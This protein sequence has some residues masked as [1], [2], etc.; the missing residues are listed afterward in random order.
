MAGSGNDSEMAN[1]Q[2]LAKACQD[3]GADAL[4][5]NL[6]CPHM[7]RQD[8]GSN[9]GK[10]PEL[11]SIVTQAVKEVARVPVWAK[12]TPST[13]D[14]IV[15][16]RG[17][18]LGGADAICSSN[19]FPSLPLID[20]E[21]LEFEINV[22]GMV[23]I[24][25]LGGPAIL[26]LSLAKMVQMTQAFPDKAFS[27]IGGIAEFGHALNYFLLGCGTVQVCTAAM[28][29]H[30][31]GP[32]VLKGLH[33]GHDGGDGAQR[34][35][36]AGR[37]HRPA[38]RPGRRALE[39]PPAGSRRLS[40]RLRGRRVRGRRP[41]GRRRRKLSRACRAGAEHDFVELTEDLSGSPLWNPDL[42]PTPLARRTWSTYHIAAL[43]IGMSVAITTYTLASGLMQQGMN[44]WQAMLT[45][46]L[47]NTIVLV[48]MILNAHAGTKYGVSFPVLCRASFG[49]K[50]ANIPAMLRALVACGWFGIQT[51]IGGLALNTLLVAAWPAWAGVSGQCLDRLRDFLGGTGLAHRQRPRGHQ[52]A[53]RL[54]GAAADRRRRAAARVG[55]TP[56]RRARSHPER[57]GAPADG[58]HP[59]LAAVSRGADRQHRLL[60]DAQPQYP[61]LHAVSPAASDR[62]RMG[63][64][65]GLPATMTAFAF[66][67]VAVTSATIVLFGEAIWDP[68]QV[69]ARIGSAP[70]I[71]FG[72]LV[73]MLAQIT[74][75]MAANVVSPAM[76]FSSLAPRR[77]S[78]VAG[79][80][81]TAVI[82][83][84]MMPWKLYA[85]AAAYIFTWLV[86]YS[87]LMGAIGGILIADYWVLRRQELSSAD[88]FKLEGRY[89]YSNGLNPRALWALVLAIA[90]GGARLPARRRHARRPGGESDAPRLAVHVR[91]VRDVRSE[92]RSVP[93]VQPP[94]LRTTINAEHAEHA[95]TLRSVASA[96]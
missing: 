11:I 51:W 1:W 24:G 95:E 37:L 32:N 94:N 93:G 62:R 78:Y 64:A 85:D 48:P 96:S 18:F 55:D 41:P 72:A 12:L 50:G 39:D 86:G 5:L 80:L 8:M 71:I 23:S 27:G 65:L 30:A 19:T 29:D 61:R 34:L 43:W 69:I 60:G 54:V 40:R 88:L 90:A 14:I 58:A 9:I 79:G 16:A 84:L 67:G 25:G 81:I 31:I 92:L 53:R 35:E 17:A 89:T 70:V 33:V 10:D 36:V 42:A 66:I 68:V 13:T 63:Q 38:A 6:S 87:S 56:G 74:T 82:G 52:E 22:D 20:P 44:W 3:E 91:V 49:V 73:V 26:P 21:T 15:E 83:I 59:V 28:L 47:G 75:N 57:I 7:D 76:D 45:I 4:E 46:L 2:T 77:I